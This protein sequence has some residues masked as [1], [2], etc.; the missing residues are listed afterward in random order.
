MGLHKLQLYLQR[1]ESRANLRF[2]GHHPEKSVNRF[3]PEWLRVYT[4]I[5]FEKH[6][7]VRAAS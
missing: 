5:V 7:L 1:R 4:L 2:T 3:D 6:L